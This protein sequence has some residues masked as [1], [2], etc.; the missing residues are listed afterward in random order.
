MLIGAKYI[1]VLKDKQKRMRAVSVCVR[2]R[3]GGREIENEDTNIC[4]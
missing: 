3:E 4:V 1:H 2:A